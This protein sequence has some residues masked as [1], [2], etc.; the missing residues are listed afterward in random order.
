M[1]VKLLKKSLV[2]RSFRSV[3]FNKKLAVLLLVE[4]CFCFAVVADLLSTSLVLSKPAV[5]REISYVTADGESGVYVEQVEG[6]ELHPAASVPA[7][8]T[9]YTLANL[10]LFMLPYKKVRLLCYAGFLVFAYSFTVNNIAVLI[11]I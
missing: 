1:T 5:S 7:T 10:A 11:S 6:T 9:L 4:A 3:V 8:L 2:K